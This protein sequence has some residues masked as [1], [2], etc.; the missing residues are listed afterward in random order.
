MLPQN[1]LVRPRDLINNDDSAWGDDVSIF[2]TQD[3]TSI[4][5][6]LGLYTDKPGN[7]SAIQ[8]DDQGYLILKNNKL[9]TTFKKVHELVGMESL[10]VLI[11]KC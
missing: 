6:F 4:V 1:R 11:E 2:T 5:H 10:T 7:P 3:L 9:R 8:P